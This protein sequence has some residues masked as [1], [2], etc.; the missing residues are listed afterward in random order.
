[1]VKQQQLQQ[2]Q[3]HRPKILCLG[4]S[5]PDVD[6][7]MAS[8]NLRPVRSPSI[9]QILKYVQMGVFT[10]M[11]GRDLCRVLSS[12][13][14]CGVDVYTV[15]QERA[16]IYRSDRH[17]HANFNRT[18]FVKQLVEEL[19]VMNVA[20]EQI[21]LDYFWIPAGWDNQH[22]SSS[23]FETTLM[24]LAKNNLLMQTPTSTTTT[25]PNVL[26]RRGI[27]LPFCL[28][29]FKEVMAAFEKT[30]RY[31]Y[32]VRFLR[33]QE[34]HE[35]ALWVG[36]QNIPGSH[37]QSILGKRCDQEEVYC[38]FTKKQI[39]QSM[40]NDH[41]ISKKQ[42]MD[43]VTSL[44][45]FGSIR[46]MVLERKN[47]SSR[48]GR[49]LGLRND[50]TIIHGYDSSCSLVQLPPVVVTPN[51]KQNL[52]SDCDIQKKNEDHI[53][54]LVERTKRIRQNHAKIVTPHHSR[55]SSPQTSLPDPDLEECKRSPSSIKRT[56]L[57]PRALFPKDGR[58]RNISEP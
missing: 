39:Q 55:G 52:Y 19:G 49:I 17:L 27:Y 20:F 21:I 37:M 14:N 35:I 3:Q 47:C 38:T 44:D 9:D 36:T 23:F 10:Q 31:W 54:A 11:D 1:M 7:T 26:L 29:S 58:R 25:T 24:E 50:S 6:A 57:P 56:R 16:G 30:I 45:D 4:V 33:K 2:Q 42:L 18:K 53:S 48:L 13:R 46:F 40:M 43:I 22:W 51:Q 15:S 41:R 12:E 32:D 5:Y 34:L 28:H 8:K